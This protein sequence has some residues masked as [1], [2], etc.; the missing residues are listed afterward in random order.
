MS[1]P[2]IS[3]RSAAV[4]ITPSVIAREQ[5]NGVRTFISI[6]NTSIAGQIVYISTGAEAKVGVGIPLSPGGFF[7]DS[8]DSYVLPSQAQYTAI[9]DALL[10]TVAIQE[11]TITGEL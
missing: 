6:T 10:A 4:T 2:Q 5:L 11:R 8:Q 1:E 7:Q 9:S 3:N